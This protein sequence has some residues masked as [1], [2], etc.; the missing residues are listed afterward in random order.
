M[1][2]IRDRIMHG[3]GTG[4]GWYRDEEV[5]AADP[6]MISASWRKPLSLVEINQ[7]APTPEVG[8]RQGRP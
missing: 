8:A 6:D 5:L 1:E 7:M 3:C 4:E 2:A